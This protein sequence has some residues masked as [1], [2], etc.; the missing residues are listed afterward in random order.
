METRLLDRARGYKYEEITEERIPIY[1]EPEEGKKRG[2]VIGYE[3]VPTKKVVKEVAP[4]VTAL[5]FWLKNRQPARWRDVK[6]AEVKGQFELNH[7][8]KDGMKEIEQPSDERSAE[9]LQILWDC[10]AFKPLI[11]KRIEELQVE[12]ATADQGDREL[13]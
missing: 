6:Q 1:G 5:I 10:D 11:E 12:K 8:L 9:I 2:A 7:E 13:H 3:M 4:D